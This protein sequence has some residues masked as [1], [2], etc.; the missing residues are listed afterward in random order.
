MNNKPQITTM[1]VVKSLIAPILLIFLAAILY[2][3]VIMTAPQKT[4][5]LPAQ[6]AEPSILDKLG[7]QTTVAV[8]IVMIALLAWV[9]WLFIHFGRRLSERGYL[10]P[11][12]SDALARAEIARIEDALREDLRKGVYA[13]T[14]NINQT[15]FRE[16]YKIPP[17]EE[18]PYL[19]PGVT[20]DESGNVL[21]SASEWDSTDYWSSPGDDYYYTDYGDESLSQEELK[22]R[23]DENKKREDERKKRED[24]RKKRQR[25]QNAYRDEQLRL[26]R[27]DLVNQRNAARVR[28]RALVPDIDVSS[29][30]GGW[31]FVLEFTTII[32]IVFTALTLGFVGVLGSEMIGTILASVAGYVLGKSST[33]RTTGGQEIV[34]GGEQPTALMDAIVKQAGFRTLT[35]DDKLA[36]QKQV[37]DLQEQLAKTKVSVPTVVKKT[38]AEAEALLQGKGLIPFVKKITNPDFE[39]DVVFDQSPEAGME[40]EKSNKVMLFVAQKPPAQKNNAEVVEELKPEGGQEPTPPAPEDEVSAEDDPDNIEDVD[41]EASA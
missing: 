7:P 19:V 17:N 10:G 13:A 40:V 31:I 12:T 39:P 36:L 38:V 2:R 30:G 27:E 32:F 23:E 4:G 20:I 14:I 9:F 3:F 6:G 18:A 11:L 34:R 22:R 37:Q 35:D 26:Y 16:R 29:F 1:D 25:F 33:I 28:A 24:E 21:K 8:I 15:E 5:T 41:E